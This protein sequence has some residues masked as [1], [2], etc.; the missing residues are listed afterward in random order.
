MNAEPAKILLVDDEPNILKALSRILRS[1]ALSTAFSGEEAL[2]AAEQNDFDLVITDYKMPDMDGISFLMKFSVLQPDAIRII[3][4]GYADLETTL[5]AINEVG[6]FRFIN[7]PWMN[8]EIIN[9]VEKGL[10]LKRI[11]LENR[12][13][14]DQIRR[15]QARLNQQE[16]ILRS[17]EAED[18]GITKVNWSEDGSIILEEEDVNL[19]V[20]DF[21]LTETKKIR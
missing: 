17:L 19:S 11:L 14:A 4:T 7:K 9:A 18:P 5:H 2:L 13:L 12:N 21:S 8:H 10:E 15:Q 1:H 16:S 3:L 20:D 6:V